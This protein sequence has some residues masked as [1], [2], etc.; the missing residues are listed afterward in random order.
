MGDKEKSVRE[1]GIRPTV[2]HR[3]KLRARIII[4]A[5]LPVDKVQGGV[6]EVEFASADLELESMEEL[7]S[8]TDDRDGAGFRRRRGEWD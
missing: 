3:A 2:Q 5:H 6:G 4:H 8:E 7:D 1:E